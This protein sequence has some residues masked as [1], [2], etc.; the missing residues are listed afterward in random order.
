MVR[1]SW[2]V[3]CALLLV[4]CGGGGG[5]GLAPTVEPASVVLAPGAAVDFDVDGGAGTL[6][7]S[8]TCGQVQ[9]SGATGS[10]VA[11]LDTGTC[12]VRVSAS[13]SPTAFAEAVVTVVS[14]E[15][16][17]VRRYG[18]PVID[19]F[20]S[21]AAGDGDPAVAAAGLSGAAWF[22]AHVGAT[23]AVVAAFG[24]GGILRWSRQIGSPVDDAAMGVAFLA[25]GDVVVVGDTAGDLFASN[26]GLRD[27]FVARL[28]GSDGATVWT[29]QLGSA[30]REDVY[31]V[32]V[33]ADGR[34]AVVGTTSGTLVPGEEVG[35]D[36]GFVLVLA[37]TNGAT[38]WRR[39]FGSTA[40][41]SAVRIAAT[42]DGG[43]LV[44]GSTQ[45]DVAGVSAGGLDAFVIAFEADG[46]EL[47]R[48]QFGTS[49]DDL[50]MGVAPA[51]DGG[52]WVAGATQGDLFAPSAGGFDAFVA[53][54][55]AL[56]AVR[57]GAQAGSAGIDAFL[58][59]VV[60]GE[61]RGVTVGQ[62]DGALFG[63][64]GNTANDF[65]TAKYAADGTL[66]NGIKHA[67]NGDQVAAA[68]ALGDGGRVL[69]VG[70]TDGPN[71]DGGALGGLDAIVWE[72]RP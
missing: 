22:G 52:W 12:R 40:D 6:V 60:D 42:A 43:L 48:W 33:T 13:G 63:T 57:W 18:T 9:G 27:V 34:V 14:G 36:D 20:I 4:G 1:A 7:W 21:V 5:G 38:V 35:G 26:E 25:G 44:A 39:Q 46:A 29:R 24:P 65:L 47:G 32:A 66:L 69:V 64:V 54:F 11:P 15:R 41:D 3:A 71:L 17:W 8:A 19:R 51:P 61:G 56:G 68:V 67:L 31:G 50:A 2:W 28:R 72:A 55:D 23:D 53:A 16:G 70:H 49:E 58:G 62:S 59:V 37:P 30:A 45:G 10:Y